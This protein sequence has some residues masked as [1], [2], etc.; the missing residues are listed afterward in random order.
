MQVLVAK[1]PSQ[2]PEKK[3]L[4]EA[5]PAS[6]GPSSKALSVPDISELDWDYL[7]NLFGMREPQRGRWTK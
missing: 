3:F 1:D 7:L 5:I 6:I 4:I 2:L